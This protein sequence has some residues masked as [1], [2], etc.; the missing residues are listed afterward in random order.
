MGADI[1]S[2][3]EQRLPRYVDSKMR[4]LERMNVDIR[5]HYW[6]HVPLLEWRDSG[7]SLDIPYHE[8]LHN[9][10]PDI[11]PWYAERNYGLFGVIGGVR[12]RGG[13]HLAGHFRG[14]PPGYSGVV[15]DY[16]STTWYMCHEL[17]SVGARMPAH[18]GVSQDVEDFIQMNKDLITKF[19]RDNVRITFGWDS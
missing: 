1:H 14:Y 19:G 11:H 17:L 9:H 16:H 3:V 15:G 13:Q 4:A 6:Q 2:Y 7:V 12:D 18:Y 10:Q 5:A 8:C